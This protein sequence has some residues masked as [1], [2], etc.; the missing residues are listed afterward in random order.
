MPT[1]FFHIRG[2]A[3]DAKDGEGLVLPDLAAARAEALRGARSLIAADVLEGRLNLIDR[4]EVEDE[5]G[6]L[7]LT[8]PFV[9]AVEPGD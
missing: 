2:G 5:D 1:Y 3:L 6:R 4:I 7:V 9:A 8:L